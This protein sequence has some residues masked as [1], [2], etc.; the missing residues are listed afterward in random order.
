MSRCQSRREAARRGGDRWAARRGVC[1]VVIA[2]R[3]GLPGFSRSLPGP[4]SSSPPS[5]PAG[6]TRNVRGSMTE[7]QDVSTA[8]G[9]AELLLR[10]SLTKMWAHDA[11]S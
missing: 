3:C 6:G 4:G 11:P 7:Q 8:E 1:G 10:L 9:T 5:P 2:E